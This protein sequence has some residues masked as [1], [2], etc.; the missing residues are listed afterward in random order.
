MQYHVLGDCSSGSEEPSSSWIAINDNLTATSSSS[1][2]GLDQ[3][4]L[5]ISGPTATAAAATVQESLSLDI[6]QV[7]G[8]MDAGDN[9]SALRLVRHEIARLVELNNL[10]TGRSAEWPPSEKT[11]QQSTT[12]SRIN[13]FLN[14]D[15]DDRIAS[16]ESMRMHAAAD[17]GSLARKDDLDFSEKLWTFAVDA[18]NYTDLVQ[19]FTAVAEELETG[20]LKPMVNSISSGD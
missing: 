13:Q 8:H 7:P 20:S 3:V 6:Y 14:G 12:S 11:Q 2:S 18:V 10:R 1:A 5:Y 15:E 19:T 17:D 9:Y 4:L 16:D